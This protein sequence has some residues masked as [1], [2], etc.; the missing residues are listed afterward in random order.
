MHYTYHDN[1]TS[2]LDPSR[3]IVFATSMKGDMRMGFGPIAVKHHGAQ[4]GKPMGFSSIFGVGK[5]FAIPFEDKD[6][7]DIRTQDILRNVDMFLDFSIKTG[8]EI[9]HITDMSAI[10]PRVQPAVIA[11][12]FVGAHKNCIFPQTWSQWLE[13]PTVP[14]EV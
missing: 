10:I 6:G 12:L 9:F 2:G 7:Y 14:E 13:V 3:V 11:R 5:S 8:Y 1:P 4:K